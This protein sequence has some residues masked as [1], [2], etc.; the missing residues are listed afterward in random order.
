MPLLQASVVVPADFLPASA[1][2]S[3]AEGAAD[4]PRRKS[5]AA[6]H[7]RGLP[8]ATKELAFGFRPLVSPR[9]RTSALAIMFV[10]TLLQLIV[11]APYAANER[12][13]DSSPALRSVLRG[14]IV[15]TLVYFLIGPIF[16]I[17]A[18]ILVRG[19]FHPRFLLSL[20][21]TLGVSVGASFV[22]VDGSTLGMVSIASLTFGAAFVL[23]LL[24]VTKPLFATDEHKAL[25]QSFGLPNFV[26][27]LVFRRARLSACDAHQALLE[28][29]GLCATARRLRLNPRVC[30][31][32]TWQHAP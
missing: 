10:C 24:L 8:Q 9:H 6:S 5:T 22:P 19:G 12:A 7:F 3:P 14:I 11:G 25:D 32:L 21:I 1:K 20:P 4:P 16:A 31:L 23:V 30:A 2:T 27:V 17:N 26:A 18:P 29:T 15:G 28:P 13:V